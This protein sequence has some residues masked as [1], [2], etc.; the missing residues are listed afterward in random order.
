VPFCSKCGTTIRANARFCNFCGAD[1]RNELPTLAP[2]D[3][4][5]LDSGPYCP[6][7]GR[8]SPEDSSHCMW[9][10]HVLAKRPL[11][12]KSYCPRCA[13]ENIKDGVFCSGCGFNLGEHFHSVTA[14]PD[15]GKLLA[16]RYLLK[17]RLGRG[18]MG[19][20]HK[21]RWMDL[22]KDVAI[23]LLPAEISDNP[24]AVSMM[25]DE[26][27]LCINLTHTGI[28]RLHT[29]EREGDL[30]FLVMEYVHGITLEQYLDMRGRLPEKEV[31]QIGRKVCDALAYAHGRKVIHRDLK[32]ANIL[33]S[34]EVVD[35]FNY[36]DICRKVAEGEIIQGLDLYEV[37]VADF[38]IAR[39]M[40]DTLSRVS[41]QEA[42]GTLLYMSPEQHRGKG[43]DH[44]TDIYSLGATLYELLGGYPPFHTGNVVY[45]ILNEDP[46]AIAGIS[47]KLNGVILKALAKRPEGRWQGV[48]EFALALSEVDFVVPGVRKPVSKLRNGVGPIGESSVPWQIEEVAEVVVQFGSEPE[49]A[50]LEVDGRPI[51]ETPFSLALLPGNHKVG[52]KKPKWIAVEKEVAVVEGM[53][54]IFW[55]LKPDFGWITVKS[56]PSGTAVEINGMTV[57]R[58]PL[59][60]YEAVIGWHE[61]V[62]KHSEYYGEDNR[63]RVNRGEEEVLSVK[64]EPRV[65]AIKV[66]AVGEK[67]NALESEVWVDGRN[68]G[69]T[70]DTLKVR[71][72]K[73]NVELKTKEGTWKG[74]VEVAEKQVNK[75]NITIVSTGEI[76]GRDSRFIAYSNRTVFDTTTSLMWAARDSGREILWEHAQD[77]CKRFT[78]GGHTDWRLPRRNELEDLHYDYYHRNHLKG[79][80]DNRKLFI[81]RF[82]KLTEGF[83]WY[84]DQEYTYP[85]EEPSSYHFGTPRPGHGSSHQAYEGAFSPRV[86]PVRDA[87]TIQG[88]VQDMKKKIADVEVARSEEGRV[89]KGDSGIEMVKIPA[90]KFLM[91]SPEDEEGR[92]SDE[93]QHEVTISKPFLIAKYP[94]TQGQWEDIGGDPI[95]INNNHGEDHPIQEVPFVF[96]YEFCNILS[97][98]EGLVP[99]YKTNWQGL[100]WDTSANGYRLPTEA[101]WE[102]ACRAGTSTRFYSGSSNDDLA[103]V[104]WCD[105]NS[106]GVVHP[107]G[108][109]EPNGFGLYDML[110][111]VGQLCWDWYG[112]Y[113]DDHVIDPK[114]LPE[115]IVQG[116]KE[117]LGDLDIGNNRVYRGGEGKVEF[118]RCASRGQV[119]D[120]LFSVGF[121][122]CRSIIPG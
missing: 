112:D 118:C 13:K 106:G 8:R 74:Q 90:G 88:E 57:G 53:K 103:R 59:V 101:E 26:A 97:K 7:C 77:Y 107:V 85:G 40:K 48:K 98:L 91:G 99:V 29:Y 3:D 49:G 86:L 71:V 10:G 119:D 34:S 80:G 11:G 2:G 84:S 100:I 33:L 12:H 87:Q 82:I 116:T 37:K 93:C 27:L 35:H 55:S 30:S 95:Y 113:T 45:Q 46:E 96:A 38:G 64:L 14:M 69:R 39:Q 120:N 19:V 92:E 52:M 102:Y 5:E 81:T 44:R 65:G 104:A 76:I 47:D 51:G 105:L 63:V 56:E 41:K 122:V 36:K 121:R 72:G 67:G 28:V 75:M 50:L 25:R 6:A 15:N 24:R 89:V 20:V 62:V 109:K 110:G 58:T 18:G 4:S 83:V 31:I 43:L 60:K 42:T 21:A 115:Q 22:E 111:N 54:P 1:R 117:V 79:K 66:K 17:E 32:P 114:G 9:C 94:I 78:R 73:R 23:K 68:V 108:Q 70:Y 16:K 61:V